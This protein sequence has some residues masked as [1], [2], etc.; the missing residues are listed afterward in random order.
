MNRTRAL[1]VGIESYSAGADWQLDGPAVDACRFV[2]CLIQ[3]GVPA[4]RITLLV[5]PLAANESAVSGLGVPVR[6]PD[7]ATVYD[8]LTREL[9]E[10]H[11]DLLFVYW[12]GHGVVD[13][14][15]NRR[16][17]YADATVHD[18]R[19]LDF[20]ALLSSLAT[21]FFPG[22]PRQILIV[23]ACQNL[24]EELRYVHSL[25]SEGLPLGT[26]VYGREQHVLFAASPGELARN[27]AGRKA[28]I[29]SS[30]LLARLNCT[31][32]GPWP[33]DVGALAESLDRHFTSLR[34][35]G[36]TD[37]TPLHLWR[38][39][40]GTDGLVYSLPARQ[41]SAGRL[42]LDGLE[43][44]VTEL[45]KIDEI[46]DTPNRQQMILLMPTAI[47]VAVEYFGRPRAHV[48]SW[49]RACDQFSTGRAAFVGALSLGMANREALR[50]VLDLVD[51][52]WPADT[53]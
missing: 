25:P 34:A 9:R 35:S 47:K 44:L 38:R 24:A 40:P 31:N 29:F 20:S 7:R 17:F 46:V 48:I 30:E 45:L 11:S 27:D 43:A 12:G 8:V 13:G 50:R 33:P 3:R 22:H 37:Q 42:S 39:T 53:R 32:E 18:K 10:D 36:D 23:D 49:I 6:Q 28:G 15:G 21:S 52:L 4:D 19:N 16:L 5:S 26:H 1:A 41:S 51:R 14:E 2:S